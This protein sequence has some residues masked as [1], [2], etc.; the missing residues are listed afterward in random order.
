MHN[1]P[2]NILKNVCRLESPLLSKLVILPLNSNAKY[3]RICQN[4]QLCPQDDK[5]A[6]CE[7]LVEFGLTTAMCYLARRTIT[8]IAGIK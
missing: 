4:T 6:T 1:K 5:Q 2:Y 3:I 8:T 7:I